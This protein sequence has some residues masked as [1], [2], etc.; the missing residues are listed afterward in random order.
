MIR[1]DQLV[2]LMI[3]PVYLRD[4]KLDIGNH[5]NVIEPLLLLGSYQES[6]DHQTTSDTDQGP[7]TPSSQFLSSPFFDVGLLVGILRFPVFRLGQSTVGVG[8]PVLSMYCDGPL[9]SR[10]STT[11]V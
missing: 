6:L 4:V 5:E 2:T 8:L 1:K 7:R 10:G 9:A 3:M 11:I